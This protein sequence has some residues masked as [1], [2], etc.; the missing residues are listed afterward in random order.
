MPSYRTR[1]LIHCWFFLFAI[2]PITQ[3]FAQSAWNPLLPPNTF[4]YPGNPHYWKN[5]LPYPGYWQQDVHYRI[6]A[7]LDE[8]KGIITGHE[9]LTYW[10]NSPDTLNVVFFHLYQ[11]AFQPGSYYDQLQKANK[12]DVRYGSYESAGLGTEVE[13]ISVDGKDL[14]T[15]PDN[16]ILKAIL[17]HALLPGDSMVFDIRFR[18]YF[19]NGGNV[20]RRMKTFDS[21]GYRHYDGVHWYPRMAVY[22]RKFGWTTDQHL[23]KEFY[24]DFGTYD[25][26]LTTANNYIVGATGY[27][28]NRD[29]VLPDTL[30]TLLD[31]RNFAHKPWEEPPSEIIPYNPDP[32]TRKTWRYHAENVHDFAFTADPTYRIGEVVW[33]NIHVYAFCREP[34][35]AGWQNAARF[36]A[37]IIKTYSEKIGPYAYHKMIVADAQ[38]GMEYPMLT[39]DGGFDPLYRDLLA[40]EI[41]HNWFFGMVGN[42]ETYRAAL[43]EGFTE[44][45]DSYGLEAL[46]GDTMTES[47]LHLSKYEKRF[48]D[49]VTVRDEEV[50]L[51]YLQHAQKDD[52]AVLSTHSSMFGS[53]LRHGGGYRMV[54]YKTATMLYNLQY[55]L[56]DSLFWGA[57]RHYFAKWSFAHPYLEDFR[58]AIIEYTHTDLNWFFDQW[59]NT[60]KKI[61][62]AVK[63]VHKGENPRE[64]KI[65]FQRKGSMQMPID[66]RVVTD[67]GSYDFYIPNTWFE[68]STDARVLPRWYGWGK[69][70]PEYTATI[71]VNG[72]IRD[73]IID[74]SGR[75]ADVYRLDNYKKCPV[76]FRYDSQ[77]MNYPDKKRYRL[78]WA[79]TLW[80]NAVDGLKPGLHLE[81]DY[82]EHNHLVNGTIWWNSNLL[83]GGIDFAEL[84]GLDTINRWP[85]SFVF[86]YEN[87]LDRLNGSASWYVHLAKT[88][89]FQS[90][91][92]G[93]RYPLKNNLTAEVFLSAGKYTPGAGQFYPYHPDEWESGRWNNYWQFRL[94]HDYKYPKGRGSL[95]GSIRSTAPLSDYDYNWVDLESKNTTR[96]GKMRLN[97]R[98]YGRL[99]S[100]KSPAPESMLYF[101]GAS[102]EEYQEV[103]WVRAQGFLPAGYVNYGIN[104]GHFQLPGGLNARGYAGYRMIQN[105][106]GNVPYPIYKGQSGIA[107]NAEL[108]FNKLVNWKPG[109]SRNLGL[110]T[111]LFGD[112]GIIDYRDLTGKLHWSDPRFDAGAGLALTIKRIWHFEE[113]KPMTLRL[114]VPFFLSNTPFSDPAFWQFRWLIGINRAL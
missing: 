68:K 64:W 54:Y 61:D 44:F 6:W 75:L 103:S 83:Q 49:P 102:P 55:V 42:N 94:T 78:E 77:L 66:F 1:F 9:T 2:F 86:S 67:R 60:T 29:E 36:A 20:R 88:D 22:D 104:T 25:V 16:T 85:V 56:G 57:M 3:S 47:T 13:V 51:M 30:R 82:M 39:L 19:D 48:R 101:A 31:L 21:W 109:I 34:H 73:V 27:L 28:L 45:L 65:T 46:D 74:P 100:G 108:E 92:A 15:E 50:Y 111:Y 69:L 10:N 71:T 99:G 76:Q 33:N 59:L 96:L 84:A 95:S 43:D 38:D 40:H 72:R 87:A 14:E 53:A 52:D 81:G 8:Q 5:K 37:A 98:L 62:Y 107:I 114:D 26:W 105:G 80:Y 35:A 93:I 41:A 63:K 70:Q 58:Q 18:T 91:K 17:P 89:G 11:N 90:F 97:T 24:G 7:N 12:R 106:P 4:R 113:W 110:V 112:A 23:D 79:P 32:S